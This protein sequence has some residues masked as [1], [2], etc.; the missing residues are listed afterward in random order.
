MDRTVAFLF[1]RAA[2]GA[3]L[4]A[5]AHVAHAQ[6]K[7]EPG[8]GNLR[9]SPTEVQLPLLAESIPGPYLPGGDGMDKP[10]T[11]HWGDPIGV[12]GPKPPKGWEANVA[13][14]VNQRASAGGGLAAM[15][16]NFIVP[17]AGLINQVFAGGISS[18]QSRFAGVTFTTNFVAPSSLTSCFA[19]PGGINTCADQT[20]VP[21]PASKGV[22][23]YMGN[24][25]WHAYSG[26]QY[27]YSLVNTGAMLY[28]DASHFAPSAVVRE[29][30]VPAEV[31]RTFAVKSFDISGGNQFTGVVQLPAV[32]EPSTALLLAGGLLAL[33]WAKRRGQVRQG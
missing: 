12:T 31:L 11:I 24:F 2:I 21:L 32:P 13:A 33:G 8:G 27:V 1:A 30:G 4:A 15:E 17:D 6:L 28:L 3:M 20:P 16:L 5:S 25:D 29:A 14:Y 10:I 18:L 22:A 23:Y 7:V 26:D 9:L 19:S